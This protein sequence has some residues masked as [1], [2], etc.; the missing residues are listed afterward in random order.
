MLP[1]PP[2]S[3]PTE[4]AL[5]ELRDVSFAYAAKRAWSLRDTR[6]K[7][8]TVEQISLALG[9]QQAVALVGESGSGKS[10]IGRIVLGLVEPWRGQILID[11]EDV[12]HLDRRK[13]RDL[14][15][16]VQLIFQNPLDALNPR[17]RLLDQ[18]AEPAASLLQVEWPEAR[19][20]AAEAMNAVGLPSSTFIRY[21]AEISGGQAQRAVIARA[22]TVKPKLLVCDEPVSALDVSVQAQIINLLSELNRNL[23][24]ALL[25]I[26]H[27]LRLVP[28]LCERGIVLNHG[29]I[30]EAGATQDLFRSPAST[31]LKALLNAVPGHKG[32][33]AAPVNEGALGP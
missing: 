29:R 23:G 32:Y 25:F 5:L 31:Y 20:I 7:G 28:Y 14:Q 22:I 11:G 2:S 19:Q 21:P 12:T 33:A 15:R 13:R 8:G 18:V 27:D 10:T 4:T 17:M 16:V 26:T 1:Q 3:Q 9:Q 30:V 6:R 24:V